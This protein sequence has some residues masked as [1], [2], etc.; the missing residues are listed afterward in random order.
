MATCCTH[1]P[2]IVGLQ[3]TSPCAAPQPWVAGTLEEQILQRYLCKAALASSVTGDAQE[4]VPSSFTKR[5]LQAL[6]QLT[7]DTSCATAA[8]YA[9]TSTIWQVSSDSRVPMQTLWSACS[10]QHVHACFTGFAS[11]NGLYCSSQSDS[12]LPAL[13]RECMPHG[14]WCQNRVDSTV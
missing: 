7:L 9:A 6:C 8:A 10:T 13:T 2:C 4:T 14:H 1:T 12:A 3:S 5:E 11:K